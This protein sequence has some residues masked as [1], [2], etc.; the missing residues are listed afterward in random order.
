MNYKII[1]KRKTYK[2]ID[3][4]LKNFNILKNYSQTERLRLLA[5]IRMKIIK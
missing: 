1:N 4:I 2:K 5:E 3:E